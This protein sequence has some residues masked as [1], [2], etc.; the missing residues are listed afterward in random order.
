MSVISEAGQ[1]RAIRYS[2]PV[3]II[4]MTLNCI[5][6]LVMGC[7]ATQVGGRLTELINMSIIEL[8]LA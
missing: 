5:C 3:I 4:W 1:I 2:E 8:T 7:L 6:L